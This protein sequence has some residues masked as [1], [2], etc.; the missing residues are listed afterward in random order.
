MK[1][2]R[3]AHNVFL[4]LLVLLSVPAFAGAQQP[5]RII[6][7]VYNS[8]VSLNAPPAGQDRSLR[9][10]L[11]NLTQQAPG[12]SY[13]L[14]AGTEERVLDETRLK[15]GFIKEPLGNVLDK[16]FRALRPHNVTHEFQGNTLVLH[17]RSG[18]ISPAPSAPQ[19]TRR[20]E[21]IAPTTPATPP[22]YTPSMYGVP[23]TAPRQVMPQD[24]VNDFVL[25]AMDQGLVQ[26][27]RYKNP[28]L[29]SPQTLARAHMTNM[30][31]FRNMALGLEP[32]TPLEAIPAEYGYGLNYGAAYGYQYGYNPYGFY[33]VNQARKIR[34]FMGENYIAAFRTQGPDR[35]M[36]RVRVYMNGNFVDTANNVN[37]IWDGKIPADSD[38]P[39]LITFVTPLEGQDA[40]F[41]ER[42]KP[43]SMAVYQVA[44]RGDDETPKI[45]VNESRFY[46]ADSTKR[47]R[48]LRGTFNESSGSC[49]PTTQN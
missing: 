47:N 6:G 29:E 10:I 1:S 8:I 40:C 32:G 14:G 4:I 48:T 26:P 23:P 24:L 43:K 39:A 27:I 36:G 30:T 11:D 15:G 41:T 9:E 42:V 44:N 25:D 2:I 49:V 38:A 37:N 17:H 33:S 35:F 5:A 13:V 31:H 28:A 22:A 46:T 7:N 3:T 16:L 19:V 20:A 45:P 18:A 12:F 34:N 21:S